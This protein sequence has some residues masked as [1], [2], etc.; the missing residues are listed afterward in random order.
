MAFSKICIRTVNWN[1]VN[2]YRISYTCIILSLSRTYT[3][4]DKVM[5]YVHLFNVHYQYYS[6]F[7][8]QL[9]IHRYLNTLVKETFSINKWKYH[10]LGNVQG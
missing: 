9:G 7:V 8:P 4:I 1:V 2:V 10:K 3:N 5:V 6:N